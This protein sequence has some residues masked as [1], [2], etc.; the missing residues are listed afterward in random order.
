MQ[1]D[2]MQALKQILTR[3]CCRCLTAEPSK[4]H[5]CTYVQLAARSSDRDL[6]KCVDRL[7]RGLVVSDAQAL[8]R[9]DYAKAQARPAF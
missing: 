1:C 5:H 4:S 7:V 6:N 3:F 2:A 9:F 8:Q